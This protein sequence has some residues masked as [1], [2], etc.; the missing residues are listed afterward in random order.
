[1]QVSSRTQ[2]EV[3]D[4]RAQAPLKL[5]AGPDER[6]RAYPF[7]H[8]QRHERKDRRKGDDIQRGAIAA[9][10]DKVID[11]QHIDGK[12]ELQNIDEHAENKSI[13]KISTANGE[14]GM[15]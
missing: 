13:S 7:A 3:E 2:L 6:P 14:E 15:H 12:R 11:L 5:D 9:G 8:G 10:E 4:G 1:M